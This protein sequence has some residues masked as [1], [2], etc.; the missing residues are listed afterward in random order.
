MTWGWNARGALPADGTATGTTGGGSVGTLSEAAKTTSWPRYEAEYLKRAIQSD[1]YKYDTEGLDSVEKGVYLD[2]VVADYKEEADECLK[3]E[4][5][6]WLQGNH[7]ANDTAKEQLYE[8]AEGKPVRRWVFRSPESEDVNGG[9]KVGQPRVGWKHTPWGRAS[10]THLPG[11]RE[12]LREQK[13]SAHDKDTQ[14]QLLAEFGPQD[15]QQAFQYFKHWVKGRPMSDAVC[16]PAHFATN[17]VV[18][19]SDFGHQM[20]NRLCQYDTEPEDRQPG[21]LATDANAYTAGIA[22]PPSAP[23]QPT[24]EAEELDIE[25]ARNLRIRIEDFLKGREQPDLPTQEFRE[26]E[27]TAEVKEQRAELDAKDSKKDLERRQRQRRADEAAPTW[28]MVPGPSI[29]PA[30]AAAATGAYLARPASKAEAP[31]VDY[32]LLT[33]AAT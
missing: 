25:E 24:T 16:L 33:G 13:Q 28:R 3:A 29:L 22:V 6:Q 23:V 17:D 1:R 30:T 27:K 10:L 4:F 19:R 26:K 7:E 32:P 12:Y 11:V 2:K 15:L 21:V 31:G 5:E 9:S 18:A 8:N 14:M 20:P